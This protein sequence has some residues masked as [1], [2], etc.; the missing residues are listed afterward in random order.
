ME[1]KVTEKS[2]KIFNNVF[3]WRLNEIVQHRRVKIS[4]SHIAKLSLATCDLASAIN[5]RMLIK[6]VLHLFNEVHLPSVAVFGDQVE[7]NPKKRFQ[8]IRDLMRPAR[9]IA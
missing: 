8:I 4:S 3:A 1:V 2:P 6:D 5:I 7:K 9:R